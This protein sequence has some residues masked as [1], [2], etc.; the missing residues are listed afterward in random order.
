MLRPKSWDPRRFY[1]PYPVYSLLIANF[2]VKVKSNNRINISVI[3]TSESPLKVNSNL[4]L[5][6][7]PLE[8]NSHNCNLISY[9]SSFNRTNEV[10]DL[11]RVSH[12]N[13]EERDALFDLCA[14]F[15]DIFHL[16]N[17]KLTST[18]HLQ[19]EINT[20]SSI[21]IHTKSYRFPDIHKNEVRSQINKMLHDGIIKPSISPWSSP[22][23]V[24]Q[25]WSMPLDKGNGELSSITGN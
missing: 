10:L 24:V 4:N 13:C 17:D 9:T 7:E 15:S 23:W 5:K 19:H 16:P 6:I 1:L 8:L 21:P 12:L 18:D 25:S 20:S 14:S 3:N 11:L 2:V 22:I